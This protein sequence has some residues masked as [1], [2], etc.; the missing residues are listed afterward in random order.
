MALTWT[1]LLYHNPAPGAPPLS[2]FSLKLHTRGACEQ[3]DLYWR[4]GMQLLTQTTE[5][6]I[7]HCPLPSA[8]ATLRWAACPS[9]P[10]PSPQACPG[11]LLATYPRNSIS[12]V[13]SH[14]AFYV[15]ALCTSWPV[16]TLRS[17]TVNFAKLMTLSKKG[18]AVESH[19]LAIWE[20]PRLENASISSFLRSPRV[21]VHERGN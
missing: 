6:D 10:G 11:P 5:L 16:C 12:P 3:R 4:F 18:I 20:M 13:L 15:P 8:P 21:S 7:R 14:R 19:Q 2:L 1:R 17:L 9:L